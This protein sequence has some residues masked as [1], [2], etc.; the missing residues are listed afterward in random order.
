MAAKPGLGQELPEVASDADLLA[1]PG[2]FLPPPTASWPPQLRGRR[3]GPGLASIGQSGWQQPPSRPPAPA[4]C[5]SAAANPLSP[6]RDRPAARGAA[7]P[8]RAPL[9]ESRSH[10]AEAGAEAGLKGVELGHLCRQHRGAAGPALGSAFGY[11]LRQTSLSR[12][13]PSHG[14]FGRRTCAASRAG[15]GR[16]LPRTPGQ[17]RGAC[18]AVRAAK[19]SSAEREPSSSSAAVTVTVLPFSSSTAQLWTPLSLGRCRPGH[20]KSGVQAAALHQAAVIR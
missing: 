7:R 13:L 1:S 5:Y 20:H 4:T 2:R 19:P 15:L 3:A 17:T 11:R 12:S 10:R 6:P 16:G 9:S 18:S 8:A 14:A